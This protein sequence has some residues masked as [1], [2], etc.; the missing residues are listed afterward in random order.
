MRP[1]ENVEEMIILLEKRDR[2]LIE[3]SIIKLEHYKISKLPNNSNISKFVAE[4]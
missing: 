4:K 3:L 1:D 2:I